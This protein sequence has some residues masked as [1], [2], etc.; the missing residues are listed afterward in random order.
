MLEQAFAQ[1]SEITIRMSGW[2]HPF[3]DL[4]NVH[5]IPRDILSGEH[6]QH[7]PRSVAATNRHDESIPL[8]DS[9]SNLC[10]DQCCCFSSY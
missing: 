6:T 4:R 5:L 3:V 7:V 8:S 2:S 9:R 10:R 1:M